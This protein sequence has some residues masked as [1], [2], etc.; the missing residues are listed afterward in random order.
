MGAG[1]NDLGGS[2]YHLIASC[3]AS[4]RRLGTDHIDLY[5]VHCFDALTP[6]EETLK[7]FDDLVSS[8]KV[9][10]IGCSNYSGWQLMKS[11]SI[12][13]KYGWPKYVSHQVFY[14]LAGRDY[15]WDL[16]PLAIDQNIATIAWSPLGWGRLTGKIRRNQPLPEVSRLHKTRD[17]GPPVPDERIYTIVEA[18]DGIAA[19]TGK[20]VPQIALNWL[21]GRQPLQASSSVPATKNNSGRIS[22]QP[23]GN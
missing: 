7:T 22:L 2:R 20:T 3:E 18:I 17:V 1:P 13:E 9:R 8:G 14:S 6:L 23:V 15:E 12:S 11:L 4:L 21:L 10:Y 5:Q 16:M 19:E